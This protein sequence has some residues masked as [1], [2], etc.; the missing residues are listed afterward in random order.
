M[1]DLQR[2]FDDPGIALGPVVA[3]AGEQPDPVAVALQAQAIAVIFDFVQ[4]AVPVR[5]GGRFDGN[6]E[7][8]HAAKIGIWEPI[9]EGIWRPLSIARPPPRP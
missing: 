9:Y 3:V 4:P 8:V 2:G 1:P 7:F 5:D 6:A